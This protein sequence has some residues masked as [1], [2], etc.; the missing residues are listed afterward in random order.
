MYV[1]NYRSL[2]I[3]NYHIFNFVTCT[4]VCVATCVHEYRI[5]QLLPTQ[6]TTTKCLNYWLSYDKLEDYEQSADW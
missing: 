1:V 6:L 5:Q 4:C 2:R 3:C